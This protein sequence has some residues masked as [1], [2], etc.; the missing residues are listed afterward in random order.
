MCV[1]YHNPKE[2]D[3]KKNREELESTKGFLM[4]LQIDTQYWR[5]HNPIFMPKSRNLNKWRKVLKISS[6]LFTSSEILKYLYKS[7]FFAISISSFFSF[8]SYM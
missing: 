6:L 7:Y 1:S 5:M 2:K 8:T 4:A 3:E